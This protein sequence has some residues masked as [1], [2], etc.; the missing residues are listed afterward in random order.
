MSPSEAARLERHAESLQQLARALVR[1]P[2]AA[3]DLVQ[4]TYLQVL[5]KGGRLPD[6][7]RVGWLRGVLRNKNRERRRADAR[8]VRREEHAKEPGHAPDPIET[9]AG[10]EQQ[11]VLVE[12]LARV[13]EPFRSALWMR[14]FAGRGPTEIA[15]TLN[16]PAATVRSR[17]HRGLAAL[18]IE[19]DRAHGDRRTWRLGLLP[20]L[21]S[22]RL[23]AGFMG[24]MMH[25]ASSKLAGSIAVAALLVGGAALTNGLLKADGEPPLRVTE[26]RRG[27]VASNPPA[28]A[29]QPAL[30]GQAPGPALESHGPRSPGPRAPGVGSPTAGPALSR[31]APASPGVV[32]RGRVRMPASGADR[33]RPSVYVIA[34][35][36][37]PDTQPA[38]RTTVDSVGH[39][40]LAVEQAKGHWIVVA[41]SPA[42]GTLSTFID[43]DTW[44]EGPLEVALA[45]APERHI[46]VVAPDGSGRRSRL[47]F[48]PVDFS[49]A[50]TWPRPGDADLGLW[51]RSTDESGNLRLRLPTRGRF[52]LRA[53]APGLVAPP[54]LVEAEEMEVVIRLAK[55][56]SIRVVLQGATAGQ[57]A[58]AGEM[59]LGGRLVR[60][61][62]EDDS[63]PLVASAQGNGSMVF[64]T[65]IAPGD[66]TLSIDSP[67]YEAI[68]VEGVHVSS[69]GEEVELSVRLR[70]RVGVG[71]LLVRIEGGPARGAESPEVLIL[72]RPHRESKGS[73]RVGYYGRLADARRLLA[74]L[75]EGRHDLY[76]VSAGARPRAGALPGV[77]VQ[78]A[79]TQEARVPLVGATMRRM[80][81][82]GALTVRSWQLVGENGGE[83]PLLSLS[84][85]AMQFHTGPE[86][87]PRKTELGPYP[88]GL[89]Q[90]LVEDETGKRTAFR[91]EPAAR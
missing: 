8:R 89:V 62:L 64:E 24:G 65:G 50:R 3:D 59:Q 69:P 84:S 66:Y 19:L 13:P 6:A 52:V 25:V 37:G 70:R 26:E 73:W 83:L 53:M 7:L 57:G 20:L 46:R 5:S 56:A 10:I 76:V 88:G 47:L 21:P 48:R 2:H 72:S 91:L 16:V 41:G 68:L 35:D 58:A 29:Q 31:G 63:Q 51:T 22:R 34:K 38:G 85:R 78:D 4:D 71:N 79:G 81:D 82:L 36:A 27:A 55:S 14:Y 54:R 77:W 74:G 23:E 80:P 43:G 86:L 44:D 15:R 49:R 39:F 75:S 42:S 40:E 67:R 28:D 87:P 17:L 12:A 1:D 11:R 60:A 30:Q 61:E 32:L 9:A 45:R 18:R 90:L 33:R